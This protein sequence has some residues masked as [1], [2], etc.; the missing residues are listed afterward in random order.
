M[1]S[2]DK[3][4][5]FVTKKG[6]FMAKKGFSINYGRANRIV[7]SLRVTLSLSYFCVREGCV[8]TIK[9]ISSI[10]FLYHT[11][12]IESVG[13]SVTL[14]VIVIQYEDTEG[15]LLFLKGN[16]TIV[17]QYT[18]NTLFYWSGYAVLFVRIRYFIRPDKEFAREAEFANVDK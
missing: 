17:L 16:I 4:V 13:I 10:S 1:F 9:I 12:L 7:L 2:I 11:V 3:K 8:Y 18:L 15:R 14:T 6:L 5:L